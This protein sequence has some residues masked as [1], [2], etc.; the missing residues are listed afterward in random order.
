MADIK[1]R[2]KEELLLADYN[3]YVFFKIE[4]NEKD[5]AKIEK[6]INLE[7]NKWTQGQPI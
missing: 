4:P 1:I 7:R 2:T 3:Y 6:T 5:V